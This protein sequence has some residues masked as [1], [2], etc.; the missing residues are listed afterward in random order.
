MKLKNSSTHRKGQICNF[1]W[2]DIRIS[3]CLQSLR[4]CSYHKLDNI[5]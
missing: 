2:V 1:R 5:F 3:N 4:A